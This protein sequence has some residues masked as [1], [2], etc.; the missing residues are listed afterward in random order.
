MIAAAAEIPFP[1]SLASWFSDAIAK[2]VMPP[3]YRHS[4]ASRNLGLPIPV[5]WGGL[6]RWIPACAGMT[7]RGGND[8]EFDDTP[9]QRPQQFLVVFAAGAPE[10]VVVGQFQI[11]GV[12][13]QLDVGDYFGEGG[14]EVAAF[15]FAALE[16]AAGDIL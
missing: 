1:L 6:R 10:A 16:G 8:G 5:P 4:G 12:L 9:L 3:L 13:E 2:P 15:Q 11:A 14:E 7:V